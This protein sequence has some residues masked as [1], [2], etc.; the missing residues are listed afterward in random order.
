M[1]SVTFNCP[2]VNSTNVLNSGTK[3]AMAMKFTHKVQSIKGK[4]PAK[5]QVPT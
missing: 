1:E 2:I 3:R 4:Q 5:F